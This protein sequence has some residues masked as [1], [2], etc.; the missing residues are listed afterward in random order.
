MT[1]SSG[2]FRDSDFSDFRSPNNSTL[3][4]EK[5][6]KIFEDAL[7]ALFVVNR[8]GIVEYVIGLND[9]PQ[10]VRMD[11]NRLTIDYNFFRNVRQDA[12]RRAL[13]ELLRKTDYSVCPRLRV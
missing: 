8:E 10:F 1:L 7:G 13:E 3:P 12:E 9:L 2:D 5:F 6:R 11:S 4:S